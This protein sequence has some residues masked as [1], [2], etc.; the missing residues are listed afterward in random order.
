ML[1][2]ISASGRTIKKPPP[3]VA[4]PGQTRG[5]FL[6]AIPLIFKAIQ[7]QCYFKAIFG[8]KK[9]FLAL[10]NMLFLI[11]LEFFFKYISDFGVFFKPKI[12]VFNKFW[13]L[14]V[15]LAKKIGSDS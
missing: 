7:E 3:L 9:L 14:R 4:D 8:L 1:Q 11:I 10:K 12:I 6:T 15:F 2:K 13:I 5:G